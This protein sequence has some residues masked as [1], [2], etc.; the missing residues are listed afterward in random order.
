MRLLHPERSSS[1]GYDIS[2]L[3][4]YETV[5]NKVLLVSLSEKDIRFIK[6]KDAAPLISQGEVDLQRFLNFARC[7]AEIS[8]WFCRF[9]VLVSS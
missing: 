2:A 9:S 8:W 4:C 7:S 6:Q 1:L 3:T 5:S